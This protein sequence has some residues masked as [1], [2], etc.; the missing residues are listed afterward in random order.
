MNFK[1]KFDVIRRRLYL[2]FYQYYKVNNYS[3]FFYPHPNCQVDKYDVIRYHSDNA[4]CLINYILRSSYYN[5]YRL[6]IAIYDETYIDKYVNYCNEINS[7]ISVSFVSVKD[8][9]IIKLAAKCAL[10]FTDTTAH[11]TLFKK[12]ASQKVVD[13][14]YFV[15]FK[16]IYINDRERRK[17]ANKKNEI[18][19]YALTTADLPARTLALSFGFSLENVLPLGL[20]R[21]DIFYDKPSLIK[22][23]LETKLNCQ[24]KKLIV[25]VPTWRNY[26]YRDGAKNN[27]YTRS[28]FGYDEL[29]TDRINSILKE[30]NSILIAKLHPLQ[31][32]VDVRSS[33]RENILL[34]SDVEQQ[35]QCSLYQLLNIAD[36]MITDYTTTYWD[37]LN[38]DK[39]V[40][41][42]FYDYD[43][44]A[45]T[46]GFS[47]NPIEFFCAGKIVKNGED[48]SEAIA[49]LLND[50]DDYKDARHRLR[51]LF[52]CH[53]DGN[54]TK[55]VAE[56]FLKK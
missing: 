27:I 17:I 8:P 38:R 24:Y 40:I 21:N 49:D 25:F 56:Y 32:N 6:I 16:N 53:C 48:L 54:S 50:K 34:Y 55:R 46:R 39:P 4:L 28:L 7:S 45:E 15:P 23:E 29:Y 51:T 12:K 2:L 1:K 11:N 35:L 14:G 52:D 3:V 18:I 30:H 36:G 10:Y 9:K 43:R 41:F 42:N 26:E 20:C 33:I 44:Y 37:F 19:D 22:E 5:N 13:L 47:F 31:C